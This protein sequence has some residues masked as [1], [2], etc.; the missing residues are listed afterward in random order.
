MMS[1]LKQFKVPLQL[2]ND[3]TEMNASMRNG[4]ILFTDY[5]QNKPVL[6]KVKM[7]DFAKDFAVVY[8]QK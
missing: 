7:K 1:G 4:G 5:Y 3:I 6:G 8:N 2:A